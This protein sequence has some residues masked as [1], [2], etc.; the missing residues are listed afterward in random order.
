MEWRELVVRACGKLRIA[1]G[2]GAKGLQ[3]A[4]LQGRREQPGEGV[5][6]LRN[7]MSYMSC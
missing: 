2:A 1:H 3:G 6:W 7:M 4:G 5:D